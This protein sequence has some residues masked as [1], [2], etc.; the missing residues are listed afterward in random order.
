MSGG[1]RIVLS[2]LACASGR[3]GAALGGVESVVCPVALAVADHGVHVVLDLVL[4]RH[5]EELAAVGCDRI[6]LDSRHVFDDRAVEDAAGDVERLAV[7]DQGVEF[8]RRHGEA[9]DRDDHRDGR[10]QNDGE[11]EL[12]THGNGRK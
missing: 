6:G 7:E 12:V 3:L 5:A 1:L 8:E 9:S 2:L 11:F 4:V 10:G